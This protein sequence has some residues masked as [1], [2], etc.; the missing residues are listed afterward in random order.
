MFHRPDRSRRTVSRR[1]RARFACI[2]LVLALGGCASD[3]AMPPELPDPIV[4]DGPVRLVAE[5]EPAVGALVTFPFGI[6][7]ELVVA[8]A[9]V[10]EPLLVLVDG[11]DQVALDERMGEL[12]AA[13]IENP[14]QRRRAYRPITAPVGSRWTR[15]FGPHQVVDAQGRLAVVDAFFQGYP[16][17]EGTAR[18]DRVDRRVELFPARRGDDRIP[19]VV[20]AAFELPRYVAPFALTGGNFL[21]DG[22][23]TA[24]FTDAL[25][26]ENAEWFDEGELDALIAAYT[27]CTNLVHLPDVEEVGIQHVD[28]WLKVLPG[29][30][31]LV[32]RPPQDHPAYAR[33]EAAVEE[34]REV[35]DASGEP[36]LVLRV[37]CPVIDRM[38]WGDEAPLAAYTNSLILN[39]RVFVPLYGVEGDDAALATYRAA[40]PDREVLGFPY[41]D[42]QSFDALHCRTRAVFDREKL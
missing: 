3:G 40:L 9:G 11:D 27:G 41:D 39:G 38:P 19:D 17:F 42:W 34:L 33:L 14:R 24:F 28:C 25:V 36:F 32:Q 29:R 7:D 12:L 2:G 1:T 22:A 6:P 37:D 15:D 21:T 18:R 10:E 23:G 30:R 35:R 5:W 26:D 13:T 16:V 31:L 8:L 20:A 4:P